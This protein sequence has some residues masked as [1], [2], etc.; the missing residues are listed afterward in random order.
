MFL[1]IILPSS[2]CSS[3][4]GPQVSRQNQKA[5]GK[6]KNIMAKPNT[7]QRKQNSFGFALG[8]C[9]CRKVFGFCCE[10]FGFAVRSLVLPSGFWFCYEVFC[11]CR[12]VFGFA[13]R[14][15]L[16]TWSFRFCHDHEVFSFCR[17]VFGFGMRYFVFAVRF[18]VLPWGI[19]FLPWGF[20]FCREVF[21]FCREVFGFAVI[22]VGHRK[23]L[24]LK[25]VK[26][27]PFFCHNQNN[28]TSSPGLLG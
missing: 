20:W 3:Y 11:F 13:V 21:C 12:E 14:F 19:L 17:E 28:S 10:V 2:S 22:V 9:F 23:F 15:L 1:A 25:R 8:I 4:G 16:L 7:S 26:C 24:P 6:N 18:S 5:H 27:P